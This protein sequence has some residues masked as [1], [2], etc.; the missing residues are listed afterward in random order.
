[1]PHYRKSPVAKEA[2]DQIAVFYV[3]EA[4]AAF[5]PQYR[6]SSSRRAPTPG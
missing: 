3:I 6:P 4:K 2:L 1:M 5:A